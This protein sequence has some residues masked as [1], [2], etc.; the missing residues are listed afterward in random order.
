MLKRNKKASLI[1]F[2][3]EIVRYWNETFHKTMVRSNEVL[4]KVES[5][6]LP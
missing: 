1:T 3:D 6:A 2:F 5:R 4:Q